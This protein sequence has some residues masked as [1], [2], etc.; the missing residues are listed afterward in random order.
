M[1]ASPDATLPPN[2]SPPL[3]VSTANV[4]FVAPSASASAPEGLQNRMDP[5]V[6]HVDGRLPLVGGGTGLA[7]QKG[8]HGIGSSVRRDAAVGVPHGTAIPPAL[9][10]G[11]AVR[12]CVVQIGCRSSM[13]SL[14]KEPDSSLAIRHAS[15]AWLD[16]YIFHLRNH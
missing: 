7:T 15:G 11:T 12:T 9:P 13:Q 1:R 2:D 8:E 10:F 16:S 5:R 3:V 6:G 4:G 14:E